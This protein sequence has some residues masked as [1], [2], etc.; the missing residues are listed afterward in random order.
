MIILI[1]EVIKGNVFMIIGFY[2]IMP[3]P[4]K[5][6]WYFKNKIHIKYFYNL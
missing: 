2:R 3:Q 1:P 6:T 5:C 4:L